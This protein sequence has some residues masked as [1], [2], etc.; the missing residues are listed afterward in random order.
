ML[1]LL[2]GVVLDG[3]LIWSHPLLGQG[4]NFFG[5]ILIDFEIFEHLVKSFLDIEQVSEHGIDDRGLTRADI[6]DEADEFAL[7][8]FEIDVFEGRMIN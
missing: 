2:I 3:H 4:A 5:E 1:R 6:T 8:D 7:L